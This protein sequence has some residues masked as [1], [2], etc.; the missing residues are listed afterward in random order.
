MSASTKGNNQYAAKLFER[1]TYEKFKNIFNYENNLD[2]TLLIYH[3]CLEHVS[4]KYDNQFQHYSNELFLACVIFCKIIYD[5]KKE[6]DIFEV[7]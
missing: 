6:L 2:S 5:L 1:F 3:K 4:R 7:F